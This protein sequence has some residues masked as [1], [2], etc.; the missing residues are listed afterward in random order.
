M[1][2]SDVDWL[3]ELEGNN[4]CADQSL[5]IETSSVRSS[6]EWMKKSKKLLIIVFRERKEK[7]QTFWRQNAVTSVAACLSWAAAPCPAELLC[8]SGSSCANTGTRDISD[9]PGWLRFPTWLAGRVHGRLLPFWSGSW[10]PWGISDSSRCFSL[11]R[12]CT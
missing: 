6:L 7:V 8:S 11:R 9:S 2:S 4:S 5:K 1:C 10:M 12:N 3:R